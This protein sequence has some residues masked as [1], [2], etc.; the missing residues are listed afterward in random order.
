MRRHST[1]NKNQHGHS[2]SLINQPLPAKA[3]VL[4][5]E[6]NASNGDRVFEAHYFNTLKQALYLKHGSTRLIMDLPKAE[7]VIMRKLNYQ[8]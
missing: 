6:D 4:R 1:R 3:A 2:N 8:L 5:Y 7:Q